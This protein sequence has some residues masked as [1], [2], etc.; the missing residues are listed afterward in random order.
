MAKEKFERTKPHCNVG[1]IG[2]IDHGKTTLTAAITKVL[3]KHDRLLIVKAQAAGGDIVGALDGVKSFERSGNS[4]ARSEGLASVASAQARAGDLDS[5]ERSAVLIPT[6]TVCDKVAGAEAFSAIATVRARTQGEDAFAAEIARATILANGIVAN[7]PKAYEFHMRAVTSI[8]AA[9]GIVGHLED[10]VRTTT[11]IDDAWLRRATLIEVA[12]RVAAAGSTDA[13]KRL[14]VEI[15][16]TRGAKYHTGVDPGEL[17]SMVDLCVSLND[18]EAAVASIPFLKH[19]DERARGWKAIAIG[20]ARAGAFDYAIAS[21]ENI[22]NDG[23]PGRMSI[24]ANG[25]GDVAALQAAAGDFVGAEL[26]SERINGVTGQPTGPFFVRNRLT[27][28]YVLGRT[29]RAIATART[30]AGDLDDVWRW[31]RSMVDPDLKASILIGAAE[32]IIAG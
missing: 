5:A 12:A 20:R 4:C 23:D 24:K 15:V 8:A 25:F 11:S 9:Q 18:F 29:Y 27:A 16:A 21:V 28:R 3:Q 31:A 2:H 10:A 13:G 14:L 6:G 30:K 17:L 1:T 32:A 26:T 22:P 7:L 19:S